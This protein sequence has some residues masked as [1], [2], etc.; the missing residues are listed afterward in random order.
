MEDGE[1]I[2]T[3]RKAIVQ[4]TR[5]SIRAGKPPVTMEVNQKMI[6]CIKSSPNL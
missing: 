6:G 3:H 1:I 4:E 5:P 2:D